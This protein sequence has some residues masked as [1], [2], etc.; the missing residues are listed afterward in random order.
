MYLQHGQHRVQ[1]V[2]PQRDVRRDFSQHV[3]GLQP[4]F[5]DLVVEHVDQEVEALLSEAG[6]RPGQLTQGLH[7]R[8]PDLCGSGDEPVIRRGTGSRSKRTAPRTKH[9]VLQTV[10]EGTA[11]P[12]GDEVHRVGVQFLLGGV[13][14][15]LPAGGELSRSEELLGPFVGRTLPLDT[16]QA[17]P[18]PCPGKAL[19]L[20]ELR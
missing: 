13:V 3:D 6:R 16:D 11:G 18:E 1:L 14:G 20:C 7:R 5:L 9:L 4:H 10:D 17:F 2:L 19:M 8:D 12:R 15:P